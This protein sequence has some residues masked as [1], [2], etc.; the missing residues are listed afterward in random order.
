MPV[1]IF[2]ALLLVVIVSV[3]VG[4]VFVAVVIVSVVVGV[5]FVAVVAAR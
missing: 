1:Y 2:K 4:V 5:V 3:V